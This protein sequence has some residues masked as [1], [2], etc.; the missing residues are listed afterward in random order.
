MLSETAIVGVLEK[1]Q[2][3]G[4]SSNQVAD[5]TGIRADPNAGLPKKMVYE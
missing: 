4:R 1:T 2:G 5:A 3:I